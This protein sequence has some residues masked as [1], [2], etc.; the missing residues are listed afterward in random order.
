MVLVAL[1]KR[2]GFSFFP[3]SRRFPAR[4]QEEAVENGPSAVLPS[5][6]ITAAD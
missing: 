4:F 2:K 6:F 5:S 1:G 3:Y